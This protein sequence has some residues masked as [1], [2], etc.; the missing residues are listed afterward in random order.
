MST[1]STLGPSEDVIS[2]H[3]FNFIYVR[4]FRWKPPAGGM[5]I[6]TTSSYLLF[7]CR[8]L[9]K[10]LIMVPYISFSGPSSK[11]SRRGCPVETVS[12][13]SALVFSRDVHVTVSWWAPSPMNYGHSET[14]FT[15]YIPK[16][17]RPS[18]YTETT[19][20]LSETV[21]TIYIIIVIHVGRSRYPPA[22]GINTPKT[23]SLDR[24]G[25]CFIFSRRFV[26][27]LDFLQECL[28]FHFPAPLRR[29][30]RGVPHRITWLIPF[31]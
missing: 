30:L 8:Y 23:S 24:V 29:A 2:S 26:L 1:K 10:F 3:T 9:A 15:G 25:F 12:N 22:G 6:P 28:L 5:V 31:P 18:L 4:H 17:M 14:V 13:H 20:G 21:I 16:S 27:G 11:S 7:A 19:P